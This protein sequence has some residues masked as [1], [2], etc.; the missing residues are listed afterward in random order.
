MLQKKKS[1]GT[2]FIFFI[3]YLILI[4]ILIIYLFEILHDL[5]KTCIAFDGK[6]T[7]AGNVTNFYIENSS[8]V[9]SFK[10]KDLVLYGK[11]LPKNATIL[12]EK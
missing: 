5:N 8:Y 3:F 1:K 9:F 11:K 6:L 7:Y 10:L 2:L 4:L 12:C